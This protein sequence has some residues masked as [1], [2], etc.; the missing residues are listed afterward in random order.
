[1]AH[2]K[3]LRELLRHDAGARENNLAAALKRRRKNGSDSQERWLERCAYEDSRDTSKV[4]I[5]S[6]VSSY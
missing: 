2:A 3:G 6:C 4:R 1:M 5:S